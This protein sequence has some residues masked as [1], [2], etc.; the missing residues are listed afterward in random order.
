MSG[1]GLWPATFGE[2]SPR[3]G[4]ESG[5]VFTNEL[6]TSAGPGPVVWTGIV[7]GFS[8]G[9]NHTASTHLI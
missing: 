2:D 6:F 4:I 5:R 8:I 7:P 3:P 9:S 1:I